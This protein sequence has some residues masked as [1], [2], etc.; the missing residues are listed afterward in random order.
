VEGA[1]ASRSQAI[2]VRPSG[3]AFTGSQPMW[4]ALLGLLLLTAGFGLCLG[5]RRH[6]LG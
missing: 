4:A 6:V 3:L 2:A 1:A 5:G